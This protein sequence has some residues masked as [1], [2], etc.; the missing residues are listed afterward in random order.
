MAFTAT[1]KNFTK[2]KRPKGKYVCVFGRDLNNGFNMLSL[3]IK[4]E[5]GFV[6]NIIKLFFQLLWWSFEGNIVQLLTVL[7]NK[8]SNI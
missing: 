4:S 8:Q 6:F 7:Q 3:L 2:V 1:W 5:L